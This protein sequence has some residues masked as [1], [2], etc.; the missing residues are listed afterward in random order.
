MEAK[1]IT[2]AIGLKLE[3]RNHLW[4]TWLQLRVRKG[5]GYKAQKDA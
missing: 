2:F 4:I 3:E 1:G 5:V